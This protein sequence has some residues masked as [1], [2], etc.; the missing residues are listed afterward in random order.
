[1]IRR[2][3]RST[4]T[5][6]LF[7]YTTL[8]RSRDVV[9]RLDGMPMQVHIEAQIAEVTLTGD[10]QYG[11]N[12]YFERAVTAAGLPSAVGRTTWST[13]AGSVLPAAAVGGG[14]L[15]WTLLGRNAAAVLSA[16]DEVTDIQ[17]LQSPSVLVR[18]N[19]EA[20]FNVG[21]K[22]PISSVSFD[23]GVGSSGT[24]N[25]V[26]YMETGT[27]LNVR[28]RVR[29]EEHTSELQSLMRISYTVFCVQKKKQ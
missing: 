15:G 8:F 23:P 17:I 16:L 11:V 3:P 21:S 6:T 1:M 5:D 27:I 24:Y 25:N 9:E 19:A 20:T 12:W 28:P 7:P 13:L 4:R 26:Q 18:N 29:S 14:G 22:I 10:L 2:P